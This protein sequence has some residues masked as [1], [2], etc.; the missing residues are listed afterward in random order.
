MNQGR[1]LPVTPY[2]Y[3]NART[4]QVETTTPTA[5]RLPVKVPKMNGRSIPHQLT[6]SKAKG[7]FASS[8]VMNRLQGMKVKGRQS[9]RS[10]ANCLCEF[11]EWNKVD[12]SLH[13]SH[14]LPVPDGLLGNVSIASVTDWLTAYMRR[15]PRG[16]KALLG[17]RW[18]GDEALH[19]AEDR[20]APN[21]SSSVEDISRSLQRLR[22]T[23]LVNNT[24]S[25][26]TEII[27]VCLGV[28]VGPRL[29]IHKRDVW[30]RP[31]M[32]LMQGLLEHLNKCRLPPR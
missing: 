11:L 12:R 16:N 17:L 14:R 29:T 6:T 18:R 22:C 25:P 21:F 2:Y 15:C 13:Q 32:I 28:P 23:W 26:E 4:R 19:E 20:F 5:V 8:R 7:R 30:Y 27:L 1:V 3:F 24:F 9:E 31:N 10:E